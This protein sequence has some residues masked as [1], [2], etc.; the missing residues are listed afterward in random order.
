MPPMQLPLQPQ[1][2]GEKFAKGERGGPGMRWP[3]RGIEGEEAA[4]DAETER[5]REGGDLSFGE[6]F[7]A[8]GLLLF[9]VSSRHFLK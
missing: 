2:E 1:P 5:G 3:K 8:R 7:F 9:A 4:A 6:H